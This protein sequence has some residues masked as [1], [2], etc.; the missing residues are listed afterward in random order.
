MLLIKYVC[1]NIVLDDSLL[2]FVKSPITC[3]I[4]NLCTIHRYKSSMQ[5]ELDEICGITPEH[6]AL[7]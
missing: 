6:I 1:Q 5:P 4:G 7:S 3:K 2:F